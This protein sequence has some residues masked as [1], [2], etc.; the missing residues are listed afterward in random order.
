[1]SAAGCPRRPISLRRDGMLASE[2]AS[3]QL[4]YV[5]NMFAVNHSESFGTGAGR[6]ADV[7]SRLHA[8]VSYHFRVIRSA[9]CVL[10]TNGSRFDFG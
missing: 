8:L 7:A 10:A 1:M 6:R 3:N 2:H 9:Q 5:E 4:I